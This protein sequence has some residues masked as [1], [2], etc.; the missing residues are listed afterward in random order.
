MLGMMRNVTVCPDCNGSGKMIKD[1]CPDC[2]GTGYVTSRKTIEVDIPAGID[3]GQSIRIREKGEP[4]VNGGERGDLFVEVIVS[5]HPIFKRQDTNIYSTMY[6]SF[7]Q[8][9]LGATLKVETVD[10]IEEYKINPGT[11]TDSKIRLKGKGVPFLRSKTT[12]GDHIVT[13]VVKVPTSLNAEQR[14]AL[15]KFEEAMEGN[16]SSNQDGGKKKGKKGS[17]RDFV[18]NLMD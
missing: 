2:R 11:Q 8:A 18:D 7:A 15:K 6:I 9:A 10:G 5:Q 16:Y 3:N 12:R 4:G 1:K 13:L 17:F 14:E